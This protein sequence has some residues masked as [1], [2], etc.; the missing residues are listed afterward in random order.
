MNL[1]KAKA[2]L[3]SISKS[4]ATK[5]PKVL[6]AELCSIIKFLLDEVERS[7][8]HSHGYTEPPTLGPK[9]QRPEVLPEWPGPSSPPRKYPQFP[10]DTPPPTRF[11]TT[12][13]PPIQTNCDAGDAK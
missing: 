13:P 10:M 7:E 9:K 4:T 6:V 1:E 3:G 2:K 12:D 11:E 8:N 5:H